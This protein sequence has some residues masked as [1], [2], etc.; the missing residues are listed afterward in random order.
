MLTDNKGTTSSSGCRLFPS[1]GYC[2]AM[3]A[4]Q[5]LY[6]RCVL[7][8]VYM[9]LCTRANYAIKYI[10]GGPTSQYSVHE[11]IG[12]VLSCASGYINLVVNYLK[13]GQ[14]DFLNIYDGNSPSENLVFYG[15]PGSNSIGNVWSTSMN[16]TSLYVNFQSDRQDVND[17]YEI[18]WSCMSERG[19]I[20]FIPCAAGVYSSVVGASNSSTCLPCPPGS[21]TNSTG[22]N[23]STGC[24][25]CRQGGY[26]STKSAPQYIYD[27]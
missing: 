16:Q 20:M 25:L 22:T 9:Y 14:G 8:I 6:D 24:I 3:S 27:R 18:E 13:L 11:N 23:T 5:L 12:H 26:C 15:L 17:G 21:Y 19:S 4:P 2:A 10:S 1:G 7:L